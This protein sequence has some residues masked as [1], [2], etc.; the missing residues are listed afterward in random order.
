MRKLHMHQ[1]KLFEWWQILGISYQH[2]YSKIS[3]M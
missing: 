3:K 2:L 1:V